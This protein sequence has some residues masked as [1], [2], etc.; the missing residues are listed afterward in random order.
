MLCSKGTK[1]ATT[2]CGKTATT[3]PRLAK[4]VCVLLRYALNLL[5]ARLILPSILVPYQVLMNQMT[6]LTLEK[7][8]VSRKLAYWRALPFMQDNPDFSALQALVDCAGTDYEVASSVMASVK[9]G[10]KLLAKKRSIESKIAEVQQDI[11]EHSLLLHL[12]CYF[13]FRLT[14]ILALLLQCDR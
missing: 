11:G 7:T 1:A 9:K 3:N 12:T 5:H 13:A 2:D 4:K 6:P 10:Q 14:N 8:K